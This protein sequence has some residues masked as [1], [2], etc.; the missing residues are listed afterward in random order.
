M[1]DDKR[2]SWVECQQQVWLARHSPPANGVCAVK[3]VD[4]VSAARISFAPIENDSEK[5]NNNYLAQTAGS[6]CLAICSP[7]RCAS[8]E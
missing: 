7:I 6:Y 5:K 2:K 4:S 1:P 8:T 3:N